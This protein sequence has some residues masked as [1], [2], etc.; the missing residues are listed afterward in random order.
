LYWKGTGKPA[1]NLKEAISI[2]YHNLAANKVRTGLTMLGMIIGTASTILVVTIA[3]T[4]RDYILQQIQGVGSNLIYLYYESAGASLQKTMSDDL[5]LGDLQAVQELPAV[6]YATGVVTTRDRVMLDGREKEVSVIGATDGYLKVRNVR[7]LSGRFWDDVD[8]RS[9]AKTCLITEEFARKLFGNL[10]VHGKSIKLYDVGFEIVGVFA[11]GV[12]TFGQSEVSAYSALMPLGTL[13]RFT[14]SDKLDIIY[15]SA[16][17]GAMVPIATQAIQRTLEQRHRKGSAYRVEN[18]TAI[19]QTAGRIATAL[20]LLLFHIGAISLIVSGIGIMNI[21]LVTVTERTKEIGIKMAIGAR[22]REI[23]FQFLTESV[24]LAIT[25]GTAGI[26]LG[27]S[28]PL[29]A[30]FLAGFDIPISWISV[31]V[32]F[33]LSFVIGVGFGIIPAQRAATLNPTEALR[34]E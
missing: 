31:V 13:R 4:G 25:G 16:R 20:A 29:M 11:E 33:L 27:I 22:R 32:A 1:V 6:A 5:N 9:S 21:M 30:K 19:L 10:D 2:A 28:G 14:M 23:L 7:V 17:S 3:L 26:L 34:Y 15:A 24:F 18:M 8:L 12:E